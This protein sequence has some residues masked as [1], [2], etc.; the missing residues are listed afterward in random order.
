MWKL[1]QT[2]YLLYP[3]QMA[4]RLKARHDIHHSYWG[5]QKIGEKIPEQHHQHRSREGG[6]AGDLIGGEMNGI[7]RKVQ[8]SGERAEGHGIH[9]RFGGAAQQR[10]DRRAN[11]QTN[12]AQQEKLSKLP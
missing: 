6:T 4:K 3:N 11:Q 7:D 2:L 10:E 9:N 5:R 8:Q 12:H 1:A